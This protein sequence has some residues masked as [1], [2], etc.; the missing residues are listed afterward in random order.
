MVYG[1]NDTNYVDRYPEEIEDRM[2]LGALDKWTRGFFFAAII[3][4]RNGGPRLR[5]MLANLT[6]GQVL[7]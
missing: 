5:V 2:F 3:P 1:E 7:L 4:L 6:L